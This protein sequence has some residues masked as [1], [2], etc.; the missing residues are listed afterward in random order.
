V[1]SE[2]TWTGWTEGI[3]NAPLT[4]DG[5]TTLAWAVDVVRGFFGENWLAEN[6]A[7]TGFVPLLNDQWWPIYNK[8]AAIR[9]IELAARIALVTAAEGT[10]DLSR[11][12]K[13][14]YPNRE[15]V[16]SKFQHLSLTLETAAFATLAGWTV[17]Y[18]QT[19]ACG[20]PA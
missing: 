5:S 17:S 12:A 7:Q 2:L 10:S 16:C 19:T 20:L 4:R 15:L 3:D 14:I 11:E 13:E 6:A 9:V 1:E 8:R 18:E